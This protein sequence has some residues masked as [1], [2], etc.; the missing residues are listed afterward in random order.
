M[1]LA[2]QWL[3]QASKRRTAWEVNDC[4]QNSYGIRSLAF[5]ALFL[6]PSLVRQQGSGHP[7]ASSGI[8]SS[9]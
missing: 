3:C 8:D 2:M 9:D 4:D 1:L 6:G 5:S 7:S